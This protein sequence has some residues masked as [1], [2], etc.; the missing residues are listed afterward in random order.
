[1]FVKKLKKKEKRSTAQT[2]ELMWYLIKKR[3]H[4]T[5]TSGEKRP[6]GSTH[7]PRREILCKKKGYKGLDLHN[8]TRGGVVTRGRIYTGRRWESGK[9]GNARERR[10]RMEKL[11]VF[12][13]TVQAS[14]LLLFA[15][16]IHPLFEVR[17][18]NLSIASFLSLFFDLLHAPS[19]L[20]LRDTI[21]LF[22]FGLLKFSL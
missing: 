16:G 19:I 6:G 15:D 18:G 20:L 13:E 10:D 9:R 3:A 17:P 11:D 2:A 7:H 22:L 4:V 8:E 12:L 14:L 21:F 1:M 5:S